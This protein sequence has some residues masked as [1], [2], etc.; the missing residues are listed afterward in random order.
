MLVD[1][2][3]DYVKYLR[4]HAHDEFIFSV[5]ADQAE[6]IGKNIKDAF[7]WVWRGVPILA[8]LS[9]VGSSWGECS[10]K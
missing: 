2:H 6:I 9:P 3:P 10:A 8:D 1:K 4:G 5:P 7:E